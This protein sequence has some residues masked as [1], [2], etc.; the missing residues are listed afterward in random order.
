[1]FALFR[2]KRYIFD[3]IV[4]WNSTSNFAINLK[5]EIQIVFF[6][7]KPN[8]LKNRK[9]YFGVLIPK[10]WQIFCVSVDN[11]FKYKP[12]YFRRVLDK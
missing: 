6:I 8:L 5:K 4:K 3:E 2:N 7:I 10:I 11:F 1:M 9:K 12:F